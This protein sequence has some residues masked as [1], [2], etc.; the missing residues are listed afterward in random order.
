MATAEQLAAPQIAE[1]ETPAPLTAATDLVVV[2]TV[3]AAAADVALAAKA[4]HLASTSKASGA[5]E[6]GKGKGKGEPKGA[7]KKHNLKWFAIPSDDAPRFAILLQHIL[8]QL[9]PRKPKESQEQHHAAGTAHA[10]TAAQKEAAASSAVSSGSG[11]KPQIVASTQPVAA[12]AAGSNSRSNSRGAQPPTPK[13]TQPE[14]DAY[15]QKQAVFQEAGPG[16][17]EYC[18]QCGWAVCV[19][20]YDTCAVKPQEPQ[21][22]PAKPPAGSESGRL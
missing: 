7:G 3:A 5:L 22:P 21:E 9:A 19:C 17:A 13:A 2:T 18:V 10:K 8:K 4:P 12:I 6:A 20:V 11:V 16:E 14:S 1:A 15:G